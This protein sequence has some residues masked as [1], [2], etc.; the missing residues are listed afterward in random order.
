MQLF[1][2][3]AAKVHRLQNSSYRDYRDYTTSP[4]RC[5]CCRLLT[6]QSTAVPAFLHKLS[7]TTASKLAQR[8]PQIR[9]YKQRT[10]RDQL[11]RESTHHRKHAGP[12]SHCAADRCV[13][14]LHIFA[15]IQNP[16]QSSRHGGSLQ[17]IHQR[18]CSSPIAAAGKWLILYP[19]PQEA[20]DQSAK[21]R[22]RAVGGGRLPR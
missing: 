19:W 4:M 1:P 15:P 9:G 3:L 11:R 10:L 14:V 7:R 13:C 17:G 18:R 16:L 6:I 5:D 20:L 21:G 2:K 8:P 12:S 22:R